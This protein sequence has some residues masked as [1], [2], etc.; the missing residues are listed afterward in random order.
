MIPV[1]LEQS[2]STSGR[3][4]T[5]AFAPELRF[6]TSGPLHHSTARH[7]RA[8]APQR[9]VCRAAGPGVL[10]K[11]GKVLREKAGGDFGRVFQGAS[12]T[13]ERLG[14][15]D[16]LIGLW[17]LENAEDTL[18]ELEEV[19]I[20]ADFGPRT[21]LKIVDTIRDGLRQ[22]RVKSQD[23]IRA[24]LR[25]A[26]L[27]VL[28]SPEQPSTLSLGSSRPGVILVVGVN[29][30][31]KTTT[32]GKLAHKLQGE[33]AKV[34]L[35]AGDTYRAAAA[36]QLQGWAERSGSQLI[37]RADQQ[38]KPASLLAAA[39]DAAKRGNTDVLI[40]DTSGRLHTNYELMEELGSC[41]EAL[42]KRMA[43]APHE[44]LL[45]LDGT[46]GLNMLNQA[47]EFHDM[48]KITGLVLTKLDGTARG[49]AVVS[50]V[51]EL[52]VPCKFVGVGETVADLQAFNAEAFVDALLPTA[53]VAA[54]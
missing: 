34:L 9:L 28:N 54:V 42:S 15:V 17:T 41:K 30:G 16:E 26:I 19:L 33:G 22:G 52:R 21:A 50:V 32:I 8:T 7:R 10:Q 51:D 43:D 12:K 2:L 31:G 48:V 18:E 38:Q 14:V 44:V 36:E 1:A 49:G 25:T 39:L 40:C 29:G 37:A 45:V 20:A 53:Q 35:A 11:L 24:A 46:T 5:C 23:D 13:R 47:R 4:C 3:D 27:K 6:R